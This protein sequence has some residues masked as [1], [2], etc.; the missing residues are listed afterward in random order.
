M[1]RHIP[2]ELVD[3]GFRAIFFVEPV[4]LSRGRRIRALRGIR[5]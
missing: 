2:E 3:H 4:E 5:I 1:H